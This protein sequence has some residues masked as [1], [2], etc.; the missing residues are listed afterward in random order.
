MSLSLTLAN[1]LSNTE[2]GA[3]LA[4]GEGI[5]DWS[6]SK[7]AAVETTMRILSGVAGVGFVIWQAFQSRGAMAR[8]IVAGLAAGVFVWIVFNVT[9]LQSRV[10][11]E[12][13]AAG[14]TAGA[15]DSTAGDP[16]A[17]QASLPRASGLLT[18]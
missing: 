7:L 3:V 10:D 16:A 6:N 11:S 12:I 9:D 13:N 8:I 2:P 4:A 5:L 18:T 1:T 15:A 17:T 14:A